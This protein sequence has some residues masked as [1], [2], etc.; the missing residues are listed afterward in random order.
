MQNSKMRWCPNCQTERELSEPFCHGCLASGRE[1]WP[2]GNEPI[3][4]RGW[5]PGIPSG[6]SPAESSL[7][8]CPNG[9]PITAGDWMCPTC[10][11][12]IPAGNAGPPPTGLAEPEAPP[13]GLPPRSP[14]P[15]PAAQF[16]RMRTL[17]PDGQPAPQPEPAHRPEPEPP[18]QAEIINGWRLDRR[19]GR[20]GDIPERFAAT[21]I[22]DS[23]AG[24]LTLYA[25]S[26]DPDPAVYAPLRKLPRDHVPELIATGRH[27]DRAYDICEPMAGGSLA[28]L[29]RSGGDAQGIRRLAAEIGAALHSFGEAGLRHRDLKPGNIQVRTGEPLDLVI[30][31]FAAARLS[32]SDLDIAAPL[33]VTL[34]TAPEAA[35]GA[36]AAA[37]DWWSLG[38]ILLEQ[39][40]HGRCFEGVNPRAFLMHAFA[41]GVVIPQDLPPG[42]QT[43]LRGLLARDRTKRW[44][45]PQLKAWL[46]GEAVDAP[47][48]TDAGIS[49]AGG[50]ALALGGRPY[51]SPQRFA[52]D[53]AD[54]THWD[55]ARDML[56]RGEI[57]TWAA[58]VGAPAQAVSALRQIARRDGVPDDFR[59]SIALKLLNENMPLTHRGDIVNPA[60]LLHHSEQ[61][62]ELISG[63]VPEILASMGSE[64]WLTR[65]K[66]RAAAVREKARLLEIALDDASLRAYLLVTSRSRLASEWEARR[67][68]FPD[69]EHAGLASLMERRQSAEEDLIILL[70]ADQGLFRLRD[71][72]IEEAA[73]LCLRADIPGFDRQ[74][75]V[76]HL[77]LSRRDLLAELRRRTGDLARCGMA[78]ADEWVEQLRLERRLP[79]GRA[80]A[81]LAVPEEQWLE[82]AK[83]EYYQRLLD[84]FEKKVTV[85][86]ARGPLVRMTI[87]KTTARIDACE[88][89]SPRRSADDLIAH[90]LRRSD[91]KFDIDPA[92]FADPETTQERRLRHL[93]QNA[94]LYKRDTGIDGLYLDFPFLLARDSRSAVKPR[95]AP[96]LL[97]PVRIDAA[98]GVRGKV[99]IAFDRDR[100]DVR[101]NPAFEAIVGAEEITR[102]REH[103]DELLGRTSLS[104]EDVMDG[105]SAVASSTCRQMARLPGGDIQ[106]PPSARQA[107]PSG[108]FFHLSYIG[109]AIVDDLRRMKARAPDDTAMAA[110]LRIAD[111]P[112]EHPT[113]A[114]PPRETD[115]FFSAAS[116]PSQEAAVFAARHAPGLLLEGPP[117]TG[118]SQTIVNIIADAIGCG[119]SA[120]VVCQ[121]QAAIDVVRKRLEKEGLQDRCVMVTDINKDRHAILQSIRDQVSGLRANTRMTEGDLR[122]RRER[123]AHMIEEIEGQLDRRHEA[124][125]HVDAH[126]GL[127]YR[128]LLAELIDL[129]DDGPRPLD[130]PRL[131]PLLEA[132]PAT[133]RA[134][135][136]ETCASLVRY[137]LPAKFERNSLHA[138]KIF[139]TDRGTLSAFR[140][141]FEAFVAMEKRC[142]D[143]L[144]QAPAPFEIADPIQ[145]RSWL[146]QVKAQSGELRASL[147]PWVSLFD[148]APRGGTGISEG[149]QL[150]GQLDTLLDMLN[151]ALSSSPPGALQDLLLDSDEATFSA[152]QRASRRSAAPRSFASPIN[153]LRYLA[154]RHLRGFLQ[155]SASTTTHDLQQLHAAIHLEGERRAARQRLAPILKRLGMANADL[156]RMAATEVGRFAAGV[157]QALQNV[158][159][160]RR[161]LESG[162]EPVIALRAAKAKALPGF[163]E[164][165][166]A[167]INRCEARLDS[168]GALDTLANWFEG[169]WIAQCRSAIAEGRSNASVIGHIAAALPT[170]EAFQ[171]FRRRAGAMDEAVLAVFERLREVAPQLAALPQDQLGAMVRR[172][173]AREIRLAIKP[174][175]EAREPALLME[176]DELEAKIGML[177]QAD[178]DIRAMNSRMLADGID[179]SRVQGSQQSWQKITRLRA[180]RGVLRSSIRDLIEN[181]R[182]LGL[183]EL[184]PVWLVNPDVASR[185]LPLTPGLFDVVI[186]DEASQMP[187]EY[188]LPTLFRAAVAVVSG[189]EKQM[190][191][192]SFFAGRIDDDEEDASDIDDLEGLSDSA[193]E[194]LNE[195][196]N[197]REIKDCPDL[198]NLARARLPATTLEVHYRSAY[199][200]LIAFSNAAFYGNRLN[201]PVQ[202][203]DAT[204]RREKPIEVI[205]VNGVYAKQTNSDEADRVV[206]LLADYWT[207]PQSDRPSIGVVT[208]NRK[209]ADLI[210]ERLEAR[211]E[212]DED[213]RRAYVEERQRRQ[214]HEDIGFFVKNVENVQG[215]ERDLIIF[216]TTFGRDAR[217]VFRR[218]FGVLGQQGGRRRL[219]VAITRAKQ[220]VIVATSIPAGDVSDLLSTHRPPATERDYLQ[221][222]LEFSRALSAQ[223]LDAGRALCRRMVTEG[224]RADR[225]RQDAMDGFRRSVEL[226]IRDLGYDPVISDGL[227]AFAVDMAIMDPGTGLYGIGIECD[228]PRHD[229][230]ARA[231][232]R[233]L[234]RARV[235]AGTMRRLHRVSCVEWYERRSHEEK[236]LRAAIAAALNNA[237]G[238]AA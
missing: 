8:V 30:T 57:A 99:T 118:K 162:P 171:Q 121:K 189:D 216:S 72:V 3:R 154:L 116:D 159:T 157:R 125:H 5:R 48:E 106:L 153:P 213:F 209:Q 218:N 225:S 208:F 191:P 133:R 1:P 91:Q 220:K 186:Y 78:R 103:I 76:A 182:D 16:E 38:M 31:G 34:Y 29:P 237:A 15:E 233:E 50:P 126:T 61:G 205:P 18:L 151:R 88:L 136:E 206:D 77:E 219:N 161:T 53:A 4:P 188:A 33:E 115:R 138:L 20:P 195:T 13:F 36:V 224:A 71:E 170:L 95:I 22:D 27:H 132:L 109:Q 94:A 42:I 97:W 40:T 19:L 181:G 230:L 117:G 81:L 41:S 87:G 10:N 89:G 158:A 14:E 150:I 166:A 128:T 25:A 139:A 110:L 37:S 221:G 143:V 202:H 70:S 190:P 130:V 47:E 84:H 185:I 176:Q 35:I 129:E 49:I 192:T 142:G 17:H 75:A 198:L 210:E 68:L 167:A 164:D 147:A 86:L 113:A 194:A 217:G 203:P 124:V 59:L 152:L 55:E 98:V 122:H 108:V 92:V 63:A 93:V 236:R 226:F 165:V 26:G 60:W 235:L 74:E 229:I 66:T 39:A 65:L 148:A 64:G 131:R 231:R 45:W 9:H 7:R 228:A 114:P 12:D 135:I 79:I 2:L 215:D 111:A 28:E 107:V 58:E 187:V 54:G 155:S 212:A 227:D 145:T 67:R 62:Y 234:W 43:V 211:A 137:W 102:W 90:I 199:R 100:E 123:L 207:Q 140:A 177:G 73:Q 80:L 69:T 52:L 197:R 85:S 179:V 56:L 46:D 134:D 193:R 196:W 180:A 149:E 83:H 160:A 168:A 214:D 204:V 21:H 184:R 104:V 105:F 141:D 169:T 32:E 175:F 120:L 174:R 238:R 23:R 51:T 178:R 222:Y 163:L 119:K 6:Q 156:D 11:A 96:I 172:I 223:D 127:S 183:F 144:A 82:P 44:G 24:V 232:A 146:A 173:I 200:E 112:A 101:L 201:V